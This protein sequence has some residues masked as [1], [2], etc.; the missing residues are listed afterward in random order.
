M[1]Q[2]KVTQISLAQARCD[3]PMSDP[4]AETDAGVNDVVG[5]SPSLAK[6]KEREADAVRCGNDHGLVVAAHVACHRPGL[7][8]AIAKAGSRYVPAP[9][10]RAC[11]RVPRWS[12]E[13]LV[14]TFDEHPRTRKSK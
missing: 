10:D 14:D 4:V 8:D 6:R 7:P 12:V 2:T 3:I 1:G 11:Q 9:L 13:R 5:E